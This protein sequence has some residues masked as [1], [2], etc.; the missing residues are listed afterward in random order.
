MPPTWTDPTQPHRHRPPGALS[1]AAPSAASAESRRVISSFRRG[2]RIW[3][4]TTKSR[5]AS[6]R[7]G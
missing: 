7:V 3:R 2:G 6:G 1:G 5:L 4:G